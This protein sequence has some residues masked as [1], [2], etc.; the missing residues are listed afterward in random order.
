MVIRK[1]SIAGTSLAV[2]LAGCLL[3]QQANA[4]EEIVV[5]GSPSTIGA[6]AEQAWLDANL[7]ESLTQSL[8]VTLDRNLRTNDGDKPVVELALNER[9]TKG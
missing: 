2:G 3:G 8:K 4:V 7:A 5:Y 6:E 1:L 9:R